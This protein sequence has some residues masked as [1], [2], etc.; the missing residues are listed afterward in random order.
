MHA[1]VMNAAPAPAH[2]GVGRRPWDR[3]RQ[4]DVTTEID[5]TSPVVIVVDA[6]ASV[7]V[8]TF[9]DIQD[10]TRV[11]LEGLDASIPVALIAVQ[12]DARLL[13]TPGAPREDLLV[14]LERLSPG[15]TTA[16]HEAVL[17][18]VSTFDEISSG[19]MV[20]IADGGDSGNGAGLREVANVLSSRE[21]PVWALAVDTLDTDRDEL[22]ALTRDADRV[23]DLSQ[24]AAPL[25]ILAALS[26]SATEPSE[27]VQRPVVSAPGRPP[28]PPAAPSTTVP[29]TL[30]SPQSSPVTTT[31][32]ST[33]PVIAGGV[34]IILALV[35]GVV[36]VGTR[37]RTQEVPKRAVIAQRLSAGAESLLTRCGR[38]RSLGEV[39][40]AAGVAIRPGEVVMAVV[41]FGTASGIILGALTGSP[42]VGLLAPLLL[43]SGVAAV[44][45]RRIR[46]R[47]REFAM[48]LPDVLTTIATA[49]RAGYSLVQSLDNVV[50]RFDSVAREELGRIS[51]E[52]RLG[53]DLAE[54]VGSSAHRMASVDL[55]WVATALEI[56]AEVGGDGARMLDT[57]AA[58]ARERM[59]LARDVAALTAE[60]R[61]SAIVLSALPPLVALAL[62]LVSPDYFEPMGEGRGPLLLVAAG[63]SVGLGWI[64]MR[65]MVSKE[66]GAD[67]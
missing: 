13:A 47:R 1:L 63:A 5:D 12:G 8:S 49:L 9:A 60:G 22:V 4:R 53:R 6:S 28:E 44:I 52:V 62:V 65:R 24:P 23:V 30:V 16:L 36:A 33:L 35:V 15:G 56:T 2:L 39:L 38:R 50:T 32:T 55:A 7:S 45:D 20:V 51:A 11:I 25:Q 31:D 59:R 18:G 42:L 58:T 43:A 37:P 19:R 41:T 34:M 48:V 26:P 61:M 66:V 67:V 40:D 46:R 64:W 29:V 10:A 54:A 27:E 14:E 21:V 57:V 17:L 3:V